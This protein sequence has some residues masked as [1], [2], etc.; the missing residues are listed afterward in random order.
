MFNKLLDTTITTELGHL[1]QERKNFRSTK[2]SNVTTLLDE[3]HPL[4]QV[5][6]K[7]IFVQFLHM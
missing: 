1:N 3:L 6:T 5:K 4:V 7:D 2:I